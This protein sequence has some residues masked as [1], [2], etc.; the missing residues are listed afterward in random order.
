MNANFIIRIHLFN[1]AEDDIIQVKLFIV[2]F[3][4]K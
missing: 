4:F 3:I 1:Y 2:K